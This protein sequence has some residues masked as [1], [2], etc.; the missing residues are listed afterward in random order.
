M[1]P[2]PLPAGLGLADVLLA[3]VRAPV[4]ARLVQGARRGAADAAHVRLLVGVHLAT[5][6]PQ[7]VP[8]REHVTTVLA[9]VHLKQRH[10][11]FP[12][13]QISRLRQIKTRLTV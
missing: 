6:L 13:L 3:G 4:L 5:V 2:A 12:H 9:N 1:S 8:V 10:N 7:R 11:R